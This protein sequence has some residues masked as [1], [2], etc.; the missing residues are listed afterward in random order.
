MLGRAGELGS[1][2]CLAGA[3]TPSVPGSL[4]TTQRL[5]CLVQAAACSSVHSALWHRSSPKPALSSL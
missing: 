2:S 5:L 4:W 1:L 3:D